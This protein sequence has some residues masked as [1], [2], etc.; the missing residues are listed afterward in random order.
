M[1]GPLHVEIICT[2]VELRVK[3]RQASIAAGG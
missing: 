2:T 1:L 3:V